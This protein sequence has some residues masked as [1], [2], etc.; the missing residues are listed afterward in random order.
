MA[1][2]AQSA[3]ARSAVRA[4]T[5]EALSRGVFGVPTTLVD[6]ELFW[7]LDS[8]PH[9]ERRLE[10]KDPIDGVDVARWLAMPAQAQRRR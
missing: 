7:G 9:L 5:D 1:A 6:G 10:G 4:Q 2:A 3:S 8:L